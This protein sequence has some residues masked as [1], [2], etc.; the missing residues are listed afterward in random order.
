MKK[1]SKKEITQEE[2]A[3]AMAFLR[4]VKDNEENVGITYI[5]QVHSVPNYTF[6]K[7]ALKEAG[8]IE[9]I[10]GRH[11]YVFKLDEPEPHHARRF[12]ET[13]RRICVPSNRRGGNIPQAEPAVE[14][15]KEAT[16]REEVFMFKPRL[17]QGDIGVKIEGDF[18]I[19]FLKASDYVL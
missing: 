17:M 4:D 14:V 13:L 6:A 5:S 8:I 3:K 2:I 1:G 19:T 7:R 12:I 16:S 9:Y 10:E 18:K 15:E 11:N